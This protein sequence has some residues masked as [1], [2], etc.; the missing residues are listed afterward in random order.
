MQKEEVLGKADESLLQVQL[1]EVLLLHLN[2]S[3]SRRA[4]LFRK[5]IYLRLG[6]GS[7]W[8]SKADVH[9]GSRNS[10]RAHQSRETTVTVEERRGI[11]GSKVPRLFYALQFF[12]SLDF[13]VWPPETFML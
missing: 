5:L 8:G 3:A 11:K 13:C 6:K 12:S 10:G 4:K 9:G 7:Q 1:E 2:F